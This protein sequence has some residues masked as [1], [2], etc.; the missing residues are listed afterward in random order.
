MIVIHLGG[1]LYFL[2]ELFLLF[3]VILLVVIGLTAVL[4]GLLGSD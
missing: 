1:I 3:I 4:G 2:I